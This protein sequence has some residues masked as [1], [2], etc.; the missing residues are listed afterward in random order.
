MMIATCGCSRA[1]TVTSLRDA[2]VSGDS[3]RLVSAVE[4]AP[5]RARPRAG[6]RRTS[7]LGKMAD[8]FGAK[9]GFL[10]REPDQAAARWLRSRSRATDGASGPRT[11]NMVPGAAAGEGPGGDALR[12][13]MTARMAKDAPALAHALDAEADARAL[14]S[15]VSAS[16]PGACETYALL[17]AGNEDRRAA[18]RRCARITRRAC[19]DLERVTGPNEHGRYGFGVWRG[20]AGALALWMDAAVSLRGVIPKSDPAVAA[21][22]NARLAVIDAAMAKIDAEAAPAGRRS[23]EVRAGDARNGP[24]CPFGRRPLRVA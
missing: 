13:A 24:A 1:R 4:G 14:M 6:A 22:L 23:D 5:T 11:R 9:Q 20:A 15:A 7:V 3:A 19:R 8:W 21:V 18:S 2:L 17:G 10:A 16:V 12:L